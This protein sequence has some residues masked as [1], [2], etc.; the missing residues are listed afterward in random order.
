[1]AWF[2]HGCHCDPEFVVM[3]HD[4]A[5]GSVL[6]VL[7]QHKRSTLLCSPRIMILWSTSFQQSHRIEESLMSKS[8]RSR[9]SSLRPRISAV[10]KPISGNP[11][12]HH[13]IDV[14]WYYFSTRGAWQNC[15]NHAFD[16]SDHR[17]TNVWSNQP[18]RR[19]PVR[20][21][22][23]AV[24]RC[25]L[26]FATINFCSVLSQSPLLVHNLS[27][28]FSIQFPFTIVA[29]N[30]TSGNLVPDWL[31]DQSFIIVAGHWM[32]NDQS[33]I[34]IGHFERIGCR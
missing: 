26:C 4:N 6:M 1:M 18:G 10:D 31:Y 21:N 27:P 19:S 16:W 20:G 12:F 24:R 23:K 34:R 8:F 9:R 15:W 11:P 7:A 32:Y 29:K 14:N 25:A 17:W 33:F 22:N 28:Q 5:A 13:S 30:W 3:T 2:V